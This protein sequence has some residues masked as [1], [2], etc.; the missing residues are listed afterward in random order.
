MTMKRGGGVPDDGPH[1]R[2]VLQRHR[3][4]RQGDYRANGGAPAHHQTL[5]LPDDQNQGETTT[6][7]ATSIEGSLV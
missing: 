6:V 1:S 2:D 4:H 5:G 7:A 3:A